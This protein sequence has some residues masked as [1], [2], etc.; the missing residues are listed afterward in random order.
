M[1]LLFDESDEFGK[2]KGLGLIPGKVIAIPSNSSIGRAHKIPH[3]GWSKLKKTESG[4]N[5]SQSILNDVEENI[6]VYF[7]H[8]FTAFPNSAK[9]RLADA[10]YNGHQ[11]SAVIQDGNIYGCQFHPEKSGSEGLKILKAFL[12]S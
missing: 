9:H 11:I 6:S 2:T 3:I 1:Q 10:D 7:V 8:S 5:W 12:E 4:S